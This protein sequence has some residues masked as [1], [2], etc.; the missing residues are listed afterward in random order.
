[1]NIIYFENHKPLLIFFQSPR[2][3]FKNRV[4]FRIDLSTE[5]L[6]LKSWTITHDI[7]KIL[8]LILKIMKLPKFLISFWN[9]CSFTHAN[10]KITCIL[11]IM[12][13]SKFLISFW[14]SCSFTRANCSKFWI[15][16]KMHRPLCWSVQNLIPHFEMVWTVLWN[17]GP[18]FENPGPVRENFSN[19]W[20][21]F[22]SL[23]VIFKFVD[24]TC[25]IF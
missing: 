15:F 18:H 2:A 8:H 6:N 21:H 12:K 24:F 13:L 20:P 10:L 17:V 11:K 25:V 1:M 7:I 23:D 14:N 4:P 22:K 5:D 16:F 19:S 3:H 9:L